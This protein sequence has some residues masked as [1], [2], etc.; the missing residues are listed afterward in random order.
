MHKRGIIIAV[1]ILG[2]FA[3]CWIQLHRAQATTPSAPKTLDEGIPYAVAIENGAATFDLKIGNSDRYLLIIGSLGASDM[4]FPLSLTAR[5]IAAVANQP[6]ERIAPLTVRPI[7]TPAAPLT[8]TYT[9]PS[10]DT[11][12][13]RDFSIHVTDGALDDPRS[14]QRIRARLIAEGRQVRVYLDGDQTERELYPGIAAELIRLFDNEVYPTSL[15]NCGD[16]CD[17]DGDGKF[18]ILLSHWLGKLQGGGTSVG[19]FVRGSDFRKTIDPP[20]GNQADVLYLNSNIAAGPRLKTL[21]AHEYTHAV[22]FSARRRLADSI[23]LDTDEEDWLN[24]A[25]AHVAENMHSSDWSNLDHRIEAFLQNPAEC[26]LVVADYYRAG[27]WRDHGCRGATYLFLRW[28]T[29]TYGDELIRRLI[30]SPHRG[31]MNLLQTTGNTF[32]DLFRHWTIA[33]AGPPLDD[34]T[35]AIQPP[36]GL[37]YLSL[38]DRIG[39]YDLH[40]IARD[41]WNIKGAGPSLSLNGTASRFVEFSAA[42]SPGTFR[43]CVSSQSSAKLQITLTK[44][45]SDALDRN[46]RQ[47]HLAAR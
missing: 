6:F 3:I 25:I 18:A 16:Y 35:T 20:F 38:N 27:R 37:Q 15:Q 31:R 26:P 36:G 8:M 24:E 42:D 10:Q 1:M 34:T 41:Q 30:H 17:V 14:Y 29:D 47:P 21:L 28:C 45:P 32:E 2:S 39:E 9:T 19:G 7:T 5:P 44:L 33:L 12:E 11:H 46:G 40:G 43:L 23:A 4:E 22:L 13:S